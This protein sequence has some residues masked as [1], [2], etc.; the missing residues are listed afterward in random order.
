[1]PARVAVDAGEAV[2]RV[3]AFDETLERAGRLTSVVRASPDRG[4][5]A[6]DLR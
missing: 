2:M 1:M 4:R 3:A 5:L 6:G